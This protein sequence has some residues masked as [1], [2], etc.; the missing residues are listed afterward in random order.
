MPAR[1]SNPYQQGSPKHGVLPTLPRKHVRRMEYL[2]EVFK[3]KR[4]IVPI[5][6]NRIRSFLLRNRIRGFVPECKIIQTR[7]WT[8]NKKKWC[9]SFVPVWNV[10]IAIA[11]FLHEM[12][13][14]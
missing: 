5:G 7:C 1:D 12:R 8:I 6:W 2:N 9:T 4:G 3:A 10:R 13:S 14:V 11:Q